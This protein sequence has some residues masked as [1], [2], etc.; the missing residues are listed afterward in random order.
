MNSDYHITFARAYPGAEIAGIVD[1]D[2]DKARACAAKHGIKR[3][4]SSI[5]KLVY[6]ARPDVIHIVTP[7]K[8]HFALAKEAMESRCNV[9]VEK[10]LALDPQEARDLYRLA[11][12][13]N[14][15]LC[16]MHNHFFDPCMS[17]VHERVEAGDAGTIIH[18]E[19]HYGL[20]TRIPAFREYPRPNV[21]PW[22]YEMPGGVYHDFMAHPLYV[23]LEYTGTPVDIKVM[24]KSFGTLPQGIPDELRILI[25]GEKAFGTLTFSFAAQPHLHFL[26][27]HGTKMTAKVDFNTMTAVMHPVSSL[28]K[29]AQKATY[30]LSESAQLFTATA[31]N[32]S[33]FIRGKLK[34]YQGMQVLMHRFY[35]AIRGGTEPPVSKEQ[36]LLVMDTMDEIWKQLRPKPLNF[37]PAVPQAWYPLRHEE[38]VLVTGGTGFLGKKL[39]EGLV[40]EGY[41]VRVLARKLSAIE[42]LQRLGVEVFF[43][44]VADKTSLSRAFEGADMVVHAA[45]GTSGKK[46]DCESATLEGTRNVLELCG[47]SAVKKLIYISSCSVYGIADRGKNEL[48]TEESPLERSPEL[49][50]DYSASKQAAEELVWAA[51]ERRA[52]PAVILRPGTIYGPGGELFSPLMGFSLMNKLF[53][54]IGDGKFVLPF[55]YL[56]NLVDAILRAM[57]QNAAT[58]NIFNVVDD[59]GIT[60]K[61]YMEK[62]IK[63]MYPGSVTVYFP[64]RVLYA[65]TWLQEI[66]CAFLKRKPFLT[67][68]RLL[69]SQ[70]NVRYDTSKIRERVEWSPVVSFEEAA[71]AII[72]PAQKDKEQIIRAMSPLVLEHQQADNRNG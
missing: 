56:D 50:G 40:R 65:V 10:P 5:G 60:K 48:V 33:N 51:M 58:G 54:V 22:L 68:Y 67:R 27:I 25:N 29:A 15:K 9:L 23:M 4:F 34:P 38:K 2:E 11:E 53:V 14:V 26:A 36:A 55:V 61:E 17:R 63:K 32:V 46:T 45:A 1:K 35:D 3:F 49:R 43:G 16:A 7:P 70:N 66:A 59:H 47:S 24:H 37:D 31:A 18:V 62:L 6:Q 30:N 52:F 42:P 12:K 28:P 13:H 57:Q 41:R 39:I 19:S 69:S 71:D 64:F 20:N 8:T 44:D 21:L 72:R